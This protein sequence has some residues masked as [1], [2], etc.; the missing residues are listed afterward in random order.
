[1]LTKLCHCITYLEANKSRCLFCLESSLSGDCVDSADFA[2]IVA[3]KSNEMGLYKTPVENKSLFIN[4]L[5]LSCHF[6]HGIGGS[7]V[8]FSPATRETGV[9]FPANA[10]FISIPC[11]HIWKGYFY[12]WKE[13]KRYEIHS[14]KSQSR[15]QRLIT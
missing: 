1:M 13:I 14:F 8:E 2:A 12:P 4:L 10:I 6:I 9:R 15:I 3:L 11:T 5:P 7:V